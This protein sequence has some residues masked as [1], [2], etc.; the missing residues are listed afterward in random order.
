MFAQ[1]LK[2][3]TFDMMRTKPKIGQIYYCVDSRCLY[4]DNGPNKEQRLRFNATIITTDYERTNLRPVIGNYYYVSNNNCL[5]LFDGRWVL[6]AGNNANYNSYVANS[7]AVISPV[8]NTQDVITNKNGDKIIDNNGLLG[9]GSVCVRDENRTIRSQISADNI[10]QYT[11]FE[12]MLDNGFLFIPNGHLPYTDLRTSYGA[13]HLDVEKDTTT[14]EIKN[15][16]ADYYGEWNN[17]GDMNVI[18]RNLNTNILPDYTPLNTKEI[19]KTFIECSTNKLIG[20]VE[21]LVKTY[22][23]IRPISKTSGIV[24]IMSVSDNDTTSVV[25]NDLGE[26]LFTNIGSLIENA[27]IN[28]KRKIYRD[29]EYHCADYYLEEYNT[30]LTLKRTENSQENNTIPSI[31]SDTSHETT[32]NTDQYIKTRVLTEADIDSIVNMIKNKI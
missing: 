5:W 30:T 8:I 9:N 31:W 19:V 18:K 16:K 1:V 10:Y 14:N 27:Q 11:K 29:G 23:V 3:T 25:K 4:K 22:I 2:V 13:L 24:Q 21:K 20:G 15:G 32:M 17:Y 12:S 26:L 6:K 28:V 7:D